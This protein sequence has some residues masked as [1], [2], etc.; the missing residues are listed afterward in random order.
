MLAVCD[1]EE[2]KKKREECLLSISSVHMNN[3]DICLRKTAQ[4]VG[5]LRDSGPIIVYACQS[6]YYSIKRMCGGV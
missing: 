3:K 5:F 4:G 6:S 1:V 2:A